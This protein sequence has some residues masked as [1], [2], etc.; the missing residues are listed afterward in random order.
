MPRAN[1]VYSENSVYEIV[2]RTREHLPMPP[3]E[4]TNEIRLGI[5]GRTQRDLKVELCHFVDM[6]NHSHTMAVSTT[7]EKLNKFHMEVK[8][9]TTDAVKAL[10]GIRSLSLWENRTGVFEVVSLDDA[11]ER[12]VYIYSNPSNASLCDS[13]DQYP[14][15]SSWDAFQRC[16]PSIDAEVIV[17]ARWY[18]VSEIPLLPA[19]RSLSPNQDAA[20]YRKLKA[21]EE[22]IEHPIVLKPFKWLEPYGISDPKEIE[23]IRQKIIARV[24]ETER[25]NALARAKANKRSVSRQALMQQRFMRPHIPKKKDRKIFLIC[26]DKETR[27][28][29]L[30]SFRQTISRC[31][32]C[33]RLAKSGLRVDWPPG[34]F[35]PWFP[36]GFVFPLPAPT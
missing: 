33:Y 9:K 25:A 12:V 26:S 1:R 28:S 5:L 36:P 11:I 8:K 27:L 6:N 30:E 15:L 17:E 23:K 10:L 4:T 31:R 22:A 24:H 19:D 29:L 35:I 7:I 2:P 13:I 21:S 14:G 32:E 16:E 34:T 3:T 20:L 18:P